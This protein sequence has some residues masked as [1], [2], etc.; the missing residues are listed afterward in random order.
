MDNKKLMQKPINEKM[1]NFMKKVIVL[2]GEPVELYCE[3]PNT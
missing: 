3:K 2:I 1:Q